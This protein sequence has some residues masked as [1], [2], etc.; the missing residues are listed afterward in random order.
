MVG[1]VRRFVM[2]L[3]TSSFIV[4]SHL[5]LVDAWQSED[6]PWS[7]LSEDATEE[8]AQLASLPSSADL[9]GEEAK[10]FDL[11]MLELQLALLGR[12]SKME[13]CRRKIL[14]IVTALS[15]KMEIPA[16]A[17]HAELIEDILTDGW[18]ADLTVPIVERARL[19]LR[20]L[21]HL[22]DQ[23]SRPILYTD[24]EDELG[25]PTG[26][27]LSP[28]ADFAA[29]KRKARAF[30]VEHE[31]HVALRKLRS[32]KP[33]TELDISELERMLLDAGIASDADIE[34]ARG[35][36]AAQ[37]RGFG[38]FLR[39]LVGLDRGAA[40]AHFAEFISD[41][42]SADQIEFISMVIEHLT[43]NGVMDPGLLY[44]SPFTDSCPDGPYGIFHE[45]AVH[46]LEES[47]RAVNHSAVV[48]RSAEA[49]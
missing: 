22:I 47:V 17:R 46:R 27:Q 8:L 1:E 32:G 15:A 37:V 14:E 2:G 21:V 13:A 41:G 12:S 48:S 45:G 18:W 39:S 43:R 34:T 35:M 38:V 42:A 23:T 16:I 20:D 36:E 44:D 49:S 30:L 29:F 24:F 33:L 5:R 28:T 11:L 9:G 7:K 25:T 40:Q 4:R 19:R 6:A 3:D 31:D 26:V 10:R